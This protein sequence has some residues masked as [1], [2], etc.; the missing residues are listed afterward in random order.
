MIVCHEFSKETLQRAHLLALKH[1]N[2]NAPDTASLDTLSQAHREVIQD[3]VADRK[4]A[5]REWTMSRIAYNVLVK[6]GLDSKVHAQE[7][8]SIYKT[9][10]HNV[11]LMPSALEN[12]STLSEGNRL[13]IISNCPHN[14]LLQDIPSLKIE[15]FFD[16]ITVSCQI[17]YRKPHELIYRK[18]SI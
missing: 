6:L 13:H 7:V 14:S 1:I 2:G 8:A 17:G 4:S 12:L 15:G 10:D 5:L 3:Y 18:A 16:N 9:H 11:S